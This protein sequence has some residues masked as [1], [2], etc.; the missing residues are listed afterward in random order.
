MIRSWR[1]IQTFV[2]K[3]TAA[4]AAEQRACV[5]GAR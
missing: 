3:E 2:A 1:G 4:A 5:C